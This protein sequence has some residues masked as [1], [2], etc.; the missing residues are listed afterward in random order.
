MKISNN[1]TSKAAVFMA[2]AATTASV[3]PGVSAGYRGAMDGD[4]M[5]RW[6]AALRGQWQAKT[7]LGD[8]S[9]VKDVKITNASG[10]MSGSLDGRYWFT[11]N[12]GM[13]VDVGHASLGKSCTFKGDDAVHTY[14][15]K[16]TEG[17]VEDAKTVEKDVDVTYTSELT[18]ALKS[19][20]L[21]FGLSGVFTAPNLMGAYAKVGGGILLYR[22]L[23]SDLKGVFAKPQDAAADVP[24]VSAGPI[25]DV[26]TDNSSWYHNWYGLFA[27]GID[28]PLDMLME[29]ASVQVEGKYN[30]FNSTECGVTADKDLKEP[31]TADGKADLRKALN[32]GR[33]KLQK[34]SL[35]GHVF[36]LGVGVRYNF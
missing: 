34:V 31:E 10:T 4:D 15:S 11:P 27:V 8:E 14:K 33:A 24:D 25:L 1:I 9:L 29:G 26:Y 36:T 28:Y 13:G 6:S 30:Y 22:S 7:I 35:G 12:I 19:T 32:A 20:K 17:E 16:V 21:T 2:L 23:A 18:A 5:E 3:S